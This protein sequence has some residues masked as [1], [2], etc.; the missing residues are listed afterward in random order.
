[1]C[2]RTTDANKIG[3][4]TLSCPPDWEN[5]LGGAGTDCIEERTRRNDG[6]ITS[7]L[8]RHHLVGSSECTSP[9]ATDTLVGP[10]SNWRQGKGR[11]RGVGGA[12]HVLFGS[13]VSTPILGMSQSVCLKEI[14]SAHGANLP[15]GFGV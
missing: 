15:N 13:F 12:L 7:N 2:G 9:S 6:I 14:C 11:D 3:L 8:K 10:W 5:G 4:G 1:M